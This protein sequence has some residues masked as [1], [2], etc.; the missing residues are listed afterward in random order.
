M[1]VEID[2][3]WMYLIVLCFSVIPIVP[4]LIGKFPGDDI[5]PEDR[6]SFKVLMKDKSLW[7]LVGILSFGVISELSVGGWLVNFLEK[8]YEWSPV[9][10]SSMLSSFFI[11]FSAARL[12]LGP[13]ID[14]IGFTLS[15][16]IVSLLAAISTVIAIVGGESYAIFFAIAGIGVAPIY[17][18]VMA[19]ISKR[20]PNDSDVV[21][22]FIVTIMGLGTVIG[23]YAIGMIIK[24][25]KQAYGTD[26][27]LAL[28][29]GLQAGYMF[30]ALCALVCGMLSIWMYVYLKRRKELI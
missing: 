17:P 2:W 16:I 5:K 24:V 27:Q 10:A 28:V 14:R 22:S 11:G 20:Y 4:A 1:G 15:L 7:L 23:N 13:I 8:T 30:I 29:R 18:T 25:V 21:I 9:A 12:F 19:F 26:T 6:M 3:R